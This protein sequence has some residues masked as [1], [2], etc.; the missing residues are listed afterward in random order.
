MARL[1]NLIKEFS[2]GLI[3]SFGF[4][5]KWEGGKSSDP[6]DTYAAQNLPPE[7]KGVHTNKGVI[8]QTYKNNCLQIFG[9]QPTANHFL[10]LTDAEVMAI[11]KRLFWDAVNGD[12]IKSEMVACAI[13]DWKYNSGYWSITNLQRVLFLRFGKNIV[14]DGVWGPKTLEAVNSVDPTELFLQYTES[15]KNFYKTGVANGAIN[16]AYLQ[17]LLNRVNAL[18]KYWNQN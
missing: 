11:F 5:Q 14:V 3:K 8:W 13:V 15:R 1:E 18:Q 4:M 16:A 17:G 10:N 9:K 2:V 7:L 6:R 12:Q